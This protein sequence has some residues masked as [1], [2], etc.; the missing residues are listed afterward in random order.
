VTPVI[1]N[2]PRTNLTLQHRPHAWH[3]FHVLCR[4]ADSQI[5]EECAHDLV[6]ARAAFASGNSHSAV[7]RQAE[8]VCAQAEHAHCISL[9]KVMREEVL[10]F[11]AVLP[12]RCLKPE[13]A[14]ERKVWR[15]RAGKIASYAD[16]AAGYRSLAEVRW[17][18]GLAFAKGLLGSG[19]RACR[20]G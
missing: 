13:F 15:L 11:Q 10:H 4:W 20:H 14:A 7:P 16:F 19:R 18:P 17:E 6:P 1:T 5:T 8:S 3:Y 2:C 9:L 12:W